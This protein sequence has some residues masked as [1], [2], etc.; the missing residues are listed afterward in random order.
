ME[1]PAVE[2]HRII[3]IDDN[4]AIHGDFR[5]TLTPGVIAT[6]SLAEATAILFG[7]P[8]PAARPQQPQFT[9]DCALQG[10]L[11]AA[12]VQ[13]AFEAGKPYHVAFVDMRMPPGWD[14]VQ[15]I[16]RLWEIDPELQVVIC[17]A[18]SDHSWDDISAKLGLT[19]R[20]LILK[21]PFDPIE[22]TQLATALSKK[23][24]LHATAQ[25]KLEQLEQMVASRTNE[26]SHAANHDKLTGLPNRAAFHEELTHAITCS[27]L[28]D[29]R[30]YAVLFLDFDR[31]KYVN[32]SLGHEVGDELLM[33]IAR[34][35]TSAL[36][37]QH[38]WAAG[39]KQ[40]PARLGGDEFVI[41]VEGLAQSRYSM[42]VAENLLRLLS[43]P[44]HLNGYAVHSTVSI[45]VTTS[46]LRYASA[47]DA[48]R[49]ADTAMYQAKAAGKARYIYFDRSMHEAVA[50]RVELESDLRRAVQNDQFLLHYQ[51][52]VS[53]NDGRLEGF[54][55]LLR[56]NHPVEGLIH[57]GAFITCCE[58]TG[59]I[60]SIG[61]WV[62]REA[63]RQL[64]QWQEKFPEAAPL[65]MSVNVSPK[66][67]NSPTLV[68]Q[69]REILEEF[70]IPYA[71]VALEITESAIITDVDS[72]KKLLAD[73]GNLGVRLY[74]DDFGTGYSSLS[75]LHQFK[76]DALKIDRS[77][78][79]TVS[80]RRDYA[81][82]VNTIVTLA[83]N[84]GMKIIAEGIE[85]AEQLS[86]LQAL[87]C[88]SAQGF[89]FS[90]PMTAL[91]ADAFIAKQLH[92]V[93]T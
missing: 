42:N 73:L 4:E 76:L 32:D 59:L 71:A 7:E 66:Q 38:D 56:W 82:V 70:S 46:D 75:S 19:D 64:H 29:S 12:M 90:R 21:K 26:L 13:S 35:L 25:L 86:L 10:Q 67:M 24:T 39:A 5:K 62:L 20:L 6:A 17:T 60:N 61:M 77:F 33:A 48:I 58:E 49:D 84:L 85:T 23:C 79:Q 41:L 88:D 40:F 2:P 45:G 55:A 74:L 72:T 54:E 43:E 44:Y 83:R 93:L 50:R 11:G 31:F 1:S 57:P 47:T 15:T 91:A 80:E 30:H 92:P 68:Q 28:D 14:G 34:R 27:L 52:I 69:V 36:D 81:A 63:C 51:P 53:L 16:Q 78:V 87:D 65:Y 8:A 9:V 18:Y 89:Y 3:V 37:L 22:V